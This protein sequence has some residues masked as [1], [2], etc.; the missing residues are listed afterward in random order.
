MKK[1]DRVRF[2]DEKKH[3]Q[4]G[5]LQVFEIKGEFVLLTTGD[6]MNIGQPPITVNLAEIK[7]IDY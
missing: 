7:E 3:K 1:N 6:Y 5:I 4:Y 2:I